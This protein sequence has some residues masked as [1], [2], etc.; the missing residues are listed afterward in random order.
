M[1]SGV[2][3]SQEMDGDRTIADAAGAATSAV[4]ARESE[5]RV[6][7]SSRTPV[8]FHI[9]APKTGTTFLQRVLWS[10]RDALRSA[11]VLYPGDVFG[12][13]VRAAFDLRKA[14]FHRYQDPDVAGTWQRFVA[15]ARE[16]DGPVV[17]S[18]EL[19]SPAT[20]DQIDTALADLSFADVH[21]VYTAR[22]LSRQIPAAW[23]EDL[24]N[25]FAPSFEE[26]VQALR[27]PSRDRQGL[28]RMFWRMQDAA[29]VLAR[30]SRDV[31]PD[32]VHVITVAPKADPPD[33]LWRRFCD[34][35]GIEPDRYDTSEA[36]ANTSLGG[37]E[38]AVL[39]RLNLTLDSEVGWP[40]YN[41]MVKHYLAQE[42]MVRRPS[43]LVMRLQPEDALWASERSA[44]MIDR[45]AAAGYDI[46]GSLDDL[47]P[48]PPAEVADSSGPF[49][50]G[51]VV[52]SQ[53]EV[54]LEEQLEVAVEALAALLLRISRLRR[55][56]V[57]S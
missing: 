44:V 21:I 13:H 17:F 25:R 10:S 55:K 29:E 36:F 41:E 19:F 1:M 57:K 53:D 52:H 24:K 18:Q 11:G 15:E 47:R 2:V 9:G 39:R 8:Y 35:V 32:H 50:R 37:A 4:G 38:A 5:S 30:W 46:V 22:E 43:P 42:V 54:P 40:L 12:A 51:D 14:G 6:R 33:L 48:L 3:A 49:T 20:H 28:G 23:Q 16:W 56:V 45:L 31:S 26:F 27:D 34:V 7:L